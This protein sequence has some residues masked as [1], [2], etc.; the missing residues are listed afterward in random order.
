MLF[1]ALAFPPLD[2]AL[3]ILRSGLVAVGDVGE[4]PRIITK[5]EPEI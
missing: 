3:S 2:L 4:F 5:T 1:G